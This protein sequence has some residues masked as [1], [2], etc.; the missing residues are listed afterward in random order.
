MTQPGVFRVSPEVLMAGAKA[1]N[2]A[3]G[4]MQRVLTTVEG[5]IN[6]LSQSWVGAPQIRYGELREEWNAQATALR[7]IGEEIAARVQHAVQS[8]EQN[9]TDLVDLIRSK[10]V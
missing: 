1:Y 7:N 10:S 9:E 2:D 4:E 8:V 3:M 5:K 6:E